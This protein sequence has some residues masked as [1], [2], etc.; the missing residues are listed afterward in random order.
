M[1]VRQNQFGTQDTSQICRHKT[2]SRR[3]TDQGAISHVMNGTIFF[4]CLTPAISAQFAALRVS[5]LPA[6]QNDGGR[7]ART[8]RRREDRG[9][10]RADDDELGLHCL[11]KFFD[12]KIRLRRKVRGHSRHPI[13]II[14][15]V[16]GNL[17]QE[18][19]V[20]FS[21][22]AKR[23]SSGWKYEETRRDSKRL[24]TPELS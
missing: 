2:P 3:H 4:I 20:E 11:Y 24:G 16:Q 10:V 21:R 6:A 1:V 19:S 22:M 7:D 12:C 18:P 8:R 23:C 5:A 14:G 13:K 17:K 9:K 15:Q